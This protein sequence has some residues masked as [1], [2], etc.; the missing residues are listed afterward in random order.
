MI[1]P[2]QLLWMFE[3]VHGELGG[4]FTIEVDEEDFIPCG[5]TVYKNGDVSWSE[6]LAEITFNYVMKDIDITKQQGEPYVG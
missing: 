2:D 6:S 3:Q 1:D 5:V 4:A